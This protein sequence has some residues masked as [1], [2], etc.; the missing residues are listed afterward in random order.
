MKKI[1][2]MSKIV[3]LVVF[4]LLS[5]QSEGQQKESPVKANPPIS[6]VN[7]EQ[8]TLYSSNI[9]QEYIIYIHLPLNYSRSDTTYPVYYVLD[10]DIGFGMTSEMTKLLS[11]RNEMPEVIVVGIAYGAYP[12]QE[13]NNRGR[14]FTPTG[15]DVRANSNGAEKFFQFMRDKLIPVIDSKYRTN[16]NDRTLSGASRSGLFS[17]YV[18]FEHPGIFNRYKIASPSLD[19]GDGAAFEY[20]KKYA[21]NHSDLPANVFLSVGDSERTTEYWKKFV[22]ILKGRNYKSLKL[23]ATLFDNAPHLTACILSEVR[24]MKAVFSDD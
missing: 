10:G 9:Q 19:W 24:G 17:L 3:L 23:K 2:I 18:L 22:E 1:I 5:I 11:Y 4:I 20:E 8:F 12:G 15:I 7:S 21:E 16:P 6:I 13:G 14:D